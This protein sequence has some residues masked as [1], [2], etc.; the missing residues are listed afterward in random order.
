MHNIRDCFYSALL[1]L[2]LTSRLAVEVILLTVGLSSAQIS[3]PRVAVSD[4]CSMNRLRLNYNNSNREH[5]ILMYLSILP[6]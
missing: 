3:G 2:L 4:I 5:H 6:I 1:A